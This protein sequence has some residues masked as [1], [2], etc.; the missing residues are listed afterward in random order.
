MLSFWR[1]E[2]LF[3]VMSLLSQREAC[4]VFSSMWVAGFGNSLCSLTSSLVVFHETANLSN[5]T[6]PV[7][8]N[9]TSVCTVRPKTDRGTS[10][11]SNTNRRVNMKP[12]HDLPNSFFVFQSF[13]AVALVPQNRLYLTQRRDFTGSKSII[14]KWTVLTG[15]TNCSCFWERSRKHLVLQWESVQRVTWSKS[16]VYSSD[17]VT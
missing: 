2:M 9:K 17:C 1:I 13:P 14:T 4:P 7:F 16:L 12:R 8:M 10:R 11:T 3:C 15:T 6:E 5:N